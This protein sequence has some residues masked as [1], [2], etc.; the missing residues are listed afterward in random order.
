M[1]FRPLD[2]RLNQALD[3]YQAENF[4]PSRNAAIN[5]ILSRALL[6]GTQPQPPQVQPQTP[7]IS[8]PPQV[9]PQTPIG[10]G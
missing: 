9:Q 3:R 1:T 10:W 2:Q 6:G 5:Q 8:T 4:L 7:P